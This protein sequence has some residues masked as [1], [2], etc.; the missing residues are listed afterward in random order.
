[1]MPRFILRTGM[2]T[3]AVAAVGAILLGTVTSLRSDLGGTDV[4]AAEPQ[5]EVWLV[6]QS[7]SFGKTFGGAIHIF[8]GTELSGNSASSAQPEVTIDLSGATA[9]LC[10]ANTGA[11]PVRPHMLFFNAARTHAILSFVASG[12]V[13]IF[14]TTSR[15]PVG[16]V[17]MTP[18]AG[19]VIQAHA[20]VPS[21][22]G[23]HIIVANQNGKL[24]Q[25]ITAMYAINSYVLDAGATLDL[26]NCTTPNG[27][28][29]QAAGIR[30]DNA[31][32]CPII[33]SSGLFTFVTLRG[34]GLFV[35]DPSATPMAIVAEYD[36]ATIHGNGCGGQ[37]AG[38]SMWLNSG[39][40]TLA[41]LSEFDVYR[42]PLTGYAASNPVNMPAPT[43]VFSDDPV[44]PNERDGHG[45]IATKHDRFMWVFDRHRAVAEIFEIA[46]NRH[47]GTVPM[48]LN[49]IDVTPDLGDLSPSGNRIFVSLRGPKP[50]TGDP[51]NST[52]PV[53]GLGVIQVNG[54]SGKGSLK[55][56]IPITNVDA[57]GVER[58]DGH[59]IRVL[60]K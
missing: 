54:A 21:P 22:D 49:G 4:S 58:A 34:G 36:A 60:V 40:G 48:R 37:Q 9:S 19:G 17:R 51:H 45:M 50:L 47:T 42:F 31:P 11:N 24:L 14:D 20:A 10:L 46:T 29:C 18:G 8:N 32:I 26:A 52:G 35:V 44:A 12:H 1:M 16:C 38:G 28:A 30:P 56:V 13:V 57:G 33:D 55:A 59:G 15:A 7:N 27:V 43:V 41:N 23:S 3:A 53:P 5:F 6:D 25:R 2:A 39:A